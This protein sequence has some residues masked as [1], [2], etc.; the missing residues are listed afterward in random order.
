MIHESNKFMRNEW[1]F[2]KIKRN[3][4]GKKIVQLAKKWSIGYKKWRKTE[5]R[6]NSA[7]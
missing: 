7:L 1:L 2:D 6:E 5:E 3:R 4:R